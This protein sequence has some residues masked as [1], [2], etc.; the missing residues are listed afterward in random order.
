MKS[1]GQ[2]L[3][4]RLGC[5]DAAS[6]TLENRNGNQAYVGAEVDSLLAALLNESGTWSEFYTA[7]DCER[8]ADMIRSAG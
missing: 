3:F 5:A 7:A 2:A 4:G 8:V 1:S 6:V